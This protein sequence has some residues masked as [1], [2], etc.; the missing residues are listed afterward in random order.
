MICNCMCHQTDGEGN[1]LAHHCMPCCQTC[2]YCHQRI[3]MWGYQAHADK[4]QETRACES[5]LAICREFEQS[6]LRP[7]AVDQRIHKIK[8]LAEAA[9]EGR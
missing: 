1:Q 9:L 5:I 4:C 8:S 3:V 6:E 7:A 2:Q